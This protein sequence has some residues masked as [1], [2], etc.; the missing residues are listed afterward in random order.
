MSSTHDYFTWFEKKFFLI[1]TISF[2]YW[3]PLSP[4][5]DIFYRVITGSVLGRMVFRRWTFYELINYLLNTDRD[6]G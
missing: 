6:N 5:I 4:L 1:F 2:L 3:C